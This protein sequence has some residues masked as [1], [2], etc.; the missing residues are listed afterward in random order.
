LTAGG[1]DEVCSANN[2]I[3]HSVDDGIGVVAQ[4]LLVCVHLGC[5]EEQQGWQEELEGDCR[6]HRDPTEYWADLIQSKE[7]RASHF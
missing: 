3:A 4:V 6:K 5:S 1:E 2:E 7:D